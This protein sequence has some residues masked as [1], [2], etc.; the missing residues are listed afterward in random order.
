VRAIPGAADALA[1]LYPD[2]R[3]CIA[4][5]ASV[6][7]RPMIERSLARVGLARYFEAI[8]CYTE[9][10][11]RKESPA[12]WHAMSSALDVDP[13]GIAMPGDTFECDVRAPR[14]LGIHAAWFRPGGW[15]S[16]AATDTSSFL[17]RRALA[18][19]GTIARRVGEL[20]AKT[21]W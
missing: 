11:V 3:L 14:A 2:Y 17:R 6:S 12:F 15:V 1:L 7:R 8:F 13:D 9:L 20:G 18:G 10:G 5:N 19:V 21:P 16:G 4:T